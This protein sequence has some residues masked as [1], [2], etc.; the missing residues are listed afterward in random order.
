MVPQNLHHLIGRNN[1]D[2]SVVATF[3]LVRDIKD[4]IEKEDQ[5]AI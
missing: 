3:F 5:N 4:I 2:G 1:H